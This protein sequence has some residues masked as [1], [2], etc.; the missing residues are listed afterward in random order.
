MT[1]E[2]RRLDSGNGDERPLDG[3]DYAILRNRRGGIVEQELWKKRQSLQHATSVRTKEDVQH[4]KI[5][6]F[7]SVVNDF[8]K[9]Y[10]DTIERACT[11]ATI[12]LQN[13]NKKRNRGVSEVEEHFANL[14]ASLRSIV[15]GD[16]LLEID[17][18]EIDDWSGTMVYFEILRNDP[19]NVSM[20]NNLTK[21]EQEWDAVHALWYE[22]KEIAEELE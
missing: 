4:E 21:I 5:K 8:L 18:E 2:A 12:R 7:R 3:L 14:L 19:L 13:Q 15:R 1:D 9:K 10:S 17:D 16:S 11:N 20:V 6:A 22:A